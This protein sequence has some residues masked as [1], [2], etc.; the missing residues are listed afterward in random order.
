MKN[1]YF[2]A[3]IF[4]LN[5][6]LLG[7]EAQL[8]GKVFANGEA[9]LGANVYLEN[10]HWGASTNLDGFFHI[11]KIPEGEY[12]LIVR[13]LSFK[14]FRRKINLSAGKTLIL[15]V[16]LSGYTNANKLSDVVVS[17]TKRDVGQRQ[18]TIPVAVFSSSFFKKNSSICLLD[19][20]ENANG[21]ASQNHCNVCNTADIRINGMEGVYT[22]VAI[23]GMPIVSSLGT[24][25]GLSGIPTSLISQVEVVKGAASSLYGSEAVAGLI[26]IITKNPKETPEFSADIWGSS[27]GEVN[28]DVGGNFRLGKKVSGLVGLNSF[29]FQNKI[30]KNHDGFTDMALIKR[31]SLF[32]KYKIDRPKNRIFNLAARLLYEDRW[33]GQTQWNRTL[34][35]SEELYAESIYTHR[36][37]LLAQY[38]LPTTERMFLNFSFVN[39]H[40]N[41]YYGNTFFL[42]N[43]RIAFGQFLGYKNLKKHALLGGFSLRYTHYDDNTP[44]TILVSGE[45]APQKHGLWGVFLEDDFTPSQ[46]HKILL[47]ARLD[48]HPE[49]KTI[50][51]PRL[52]YRYQSPW[53]VWR[54]NAGTGFR[55]VNLFSEDHAALTGARQVV[56]KN[57]LNP[58]K[59]YNINL[60]FNKEFYF[61]NS[62]FNVDCSAFFTYFTNKIIGDFETDANKIFYD[63]LSG[64]A[65][66]RGIS[67]NTEFS[68][69]G[70]LKIALSATL[71]DTPVTQKNEQNQ[72]ETRQ[73]ILTEKLLANASVAYKIPQW[74]LLIDYTASL[75]SPMRMPLLGELDPRPENSP[76][77]SVHNV[78]FT[79]SATPKIEFYL[80]VKNLWDWVPY[81]HLPFLIARADDPFDKQVTFDAQG[82]ALPTPNNPYA[83]T[84][85]PSYTYA[86]N[87][88]IRG[89]FGMRFTF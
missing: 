56:I 29:I 46:N 19:A 9:I 30:D 12:T 60:N 69:L 49:H 26:N 25:Y 59:S 2:I 77:W 39:H 42:A 16:D 32:Q 27:W 13:H 28:A 62:I 33:G 43:Q 23:D 78:Q 61:K 57:H 87:Q 65:I 67:L 50:F 88:G 8:Q 80:G 79:Y 6:S 89:F 15:S 4:M 82:Q 11:S 75:H 84:F 70:R 66:S 34:R 73:Q 55:V 31:V 10:T 20:L 1:L 53:G 64:Y 24:V 52:G 14:T 35:G 17:S 45:N 81:R 85:D 22:M 38:Q 44:A 5:V 40:Q 76:W 21:V 63:N 3:F 74:K 71:M 41:S 51:S 18:S 72:W 83:L 36:S 7:Q 37:E 86:P 47:G 54:L 58:E 68:H 48:Y